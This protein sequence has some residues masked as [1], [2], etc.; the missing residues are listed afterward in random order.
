MLLCTKGLTRHFGG[1]K[2]VQNVDWEIG[3]GQ[4]HCIIGPNG[5][6]KSTFFHLLTGTHRPTSGQISFE[7]KDITR[8]HPFQRAR[9]GISMKPQSIGVFDHLSLETNLRIALQRATEGTLVD[10]A[11]SRELERLN[12]ADKRHHLV[13]EISH[14]EKQWLG[15]GMAMALR[16][17]LLLLD[18]PTAGMSTTETHATANLIKRIAADETSVVVVEHDMAFVRD[19]GADIS[20]FHNGELFASGTLKEIEEHDEVRRLYLGERGAERLKQRTGE[21][22]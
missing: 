15:L 10:D 7:G 9:A 14:G 20:V 21:V 19:L 16:P 17:K 1:V 5:A 8:L 18:E 13:R 22:S 2:A 4:T 12:L 3:A 11:I 6:G